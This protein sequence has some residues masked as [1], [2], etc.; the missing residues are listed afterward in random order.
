MRRALLYV[1]CVVLALLLLTPAAAGAATSTATQIHQL[2]K[3]VKA[4]QARTARQGLQIKTLQAQVAAKHALLNGS[5]APVAALGTG[6][7]FY[8]DT[9]ATAL[10]GPQTASGWGTPISL[11]GPTGAAGATGPQGLRGATGATGPQGPKGD[12]GA[13]GPGPRGRHRCHRRG[14]SRW[15]AGPD[16]CG[17]TARP[18][19]RRRPRWVS[20]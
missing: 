14:W 20:G 17:R 15:S 19:R 2:Q 16:W 11:I 18:K 7:D 10:Y 9:A 12:A 13:T 8:L 1:V 5:G 6:G 3:A 4:L